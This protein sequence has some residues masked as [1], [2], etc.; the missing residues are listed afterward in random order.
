MQAD[1]DEYANEAGTQDCMRLV[2]SRRLAL[3]SLRSAASAFPPRPVLI[4]GEP[5]A[6]KASLIRRFA[7][8]AGG[9]WRIACVDLAAGMNALDFLRLA[10][11]SAQSVGEQPARQSARIRSP[12]RPEAD[13]AT[14]WPP[15][16]AGRQSGATRRL[17]G[18]SGTKC[19]AIA[20]QLGQAKAAGLLGL[21]VV[22]TWT[23]VARSLVWRR[24][25]KTVAALFSL[26]IHLKPDRPGRSARVARSR[27]GNW[28]L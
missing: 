12:R 15:L 17:L 1:H 23:D 7:A 26:H 25:S 28:T 6:G 21:F 2:A 14:E 16:A 5:G 27:P 11:H 9:A 18:K 13:E 22:G 20:N 4:S 8:E 19:K 10:G 3:E 24:S